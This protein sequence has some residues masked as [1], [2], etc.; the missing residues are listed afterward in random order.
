MSDT[1]RPKSSGDKLSTN[2]INQDLPIQMTAGETINGATLPVPLYVSSAD[3]EVYACDGNDTSKLE[4][5]GFAVSNSTDGNSIT[6]QKD[7]VVSGFSGLTVG[8]KYY[9]QDTVGTIGTSVGTYEIYVGRAISATQILIEKFDYETHQKIT[10]SD[11]LKASSD[12]EASTSD[13]VETKMKSDIAIYCAGTVRVKFDAKDSGA[14]STFK[15]YINDVAVGTSR[16]T[17]SSYQTFSQDFNVVPGDKISV[18]LVTYV[19]GT[20]YVRNFRIYF[21]TS[22]VTYTIA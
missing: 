11:N 21:D 17:T 5:I 22:K 18:Y 10:A 14:G 13:N 3:G 6:V 8:S 19:S 20:K 16:A 12:S 4:F 1:A 2:E 9:V 7:G 15:V